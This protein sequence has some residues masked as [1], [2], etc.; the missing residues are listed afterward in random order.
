[1][2]EAEIKQRILKSLDDFNLKELTFVEKILKE[3]NDYFKSNKSLS[4]NSGYLPE[5]DPLAQL[6][7]SD[8]IGCFSDEPDFA[9]KSEKIAKVILGKKDI[10]SS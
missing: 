7:N 3:I 9:E 1:M 4:F 2:T 8:F 6:R 10:G 5:N